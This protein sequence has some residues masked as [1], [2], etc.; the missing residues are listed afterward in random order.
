ML[1][2]I[3]GLW[4]GE[5]VECQE[6]RQ[7]GW[8]CWRWKGK[9]M[10]RGDVLWSIMKNDLS[11][12]TYKEEPSMTSSNSTF[13]L[14]SKT[15]KTNPVPY[16]I[17]SNLEGRSWD[18]QWFRPAFPILIFL[19]NYEQNFCQPNTNLLQSKPLSYHAKIAK[20]LTYLFTKCI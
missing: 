3:L 12:D 8:H 9:E 13:S 14:W 11:A 4:V 16:W 2:R 6:G 1:G 15:G 10:M 17:D 5:E 18:S 7:R 20:A 19:E